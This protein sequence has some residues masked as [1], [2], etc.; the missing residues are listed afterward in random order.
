MPKVVLYLVSRESSSKV[1]EEKEKLQNSLFAIV[2]SLQSNL[3]SD[4]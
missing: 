4:G 1:A 3:I 2:G